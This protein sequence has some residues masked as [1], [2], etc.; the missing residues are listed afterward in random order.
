MGLLA[1][2]VARSDGLTPALVLV[3]VC[4]VLLQVLPQWHTGRA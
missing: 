3:P 4:F 2:A 1:D